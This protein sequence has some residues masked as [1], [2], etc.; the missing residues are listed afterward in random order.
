MILL[1]TDIINQ[2][3]SIFQIIKCAD[4]EII[5]LKKKQNMNII[6]LR[7]SRTQ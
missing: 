6:R 4:L 5:E 2:A 3:I 7:E 1:S